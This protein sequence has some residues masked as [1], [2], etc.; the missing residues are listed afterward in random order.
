MKKVFVFV[1]LFVSINA[2]ADKRVSGYFKSNGTY[3][4]SH[5]RTNA[6][7]TKRDNFS[8]YGNINPYTG[9]VGTKKYYRH[10]K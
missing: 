5:M 2:F 10:S 7:N 9:K 1:F 6:N 8:T 4:N 3:V